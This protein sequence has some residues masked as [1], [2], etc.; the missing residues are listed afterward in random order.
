MSILEIYH[1]HWCLVDSRLSFFQLISPFV[2]IFI[3]IFVALDAQAVVKC[4]EETV[5]SVW[6]KNNLNPEWNIQCIFYRRKPDVPITVEV[7][8]LPSTSTAFHMTKVPP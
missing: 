8:P 3:D 4:E 6:V 7:R 2:K 1:L 5:K